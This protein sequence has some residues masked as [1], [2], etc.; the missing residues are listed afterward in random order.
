MNL[1]VLGP[2]A[3]SKRVLPDAASPGSVEALLLLFWPKCQTPQKLRRVPQRP[4]QGLQWCS[5]AVC[6]SC[7]PATGWFCFSVCG[8]GAGAVVHVVHRS[9]WCLGV[10]LVLWWP[11]GGVQVRCVLPTGMAKQFTCN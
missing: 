3:V 1:G 4:V 8:G 2:G 7:V 11:L 10:P 5:S 6:S 9:L